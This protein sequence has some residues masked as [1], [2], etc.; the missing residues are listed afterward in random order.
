MRL[1]EQL[2]QNST[3][4][5]TIG[6]YAINL[7]RSPDRWLRLA[8]QAEELD[9]RLVRIT[10]VD[11]SQVP[12]AE[13][14]NCDERTFSRNNGRTILPGEYGCYRSHLKALSTFLE[15]NQPI[16][17]I[18]EDDIAFSGDLGSRVSAAFDALPDAEVIKLCNHRIVWFKQSARTAL[19]DEV[20]RA[21]WGPQGSAACYAVT[22]AGAAKLID[23]LARMDHPWDI[24][25]ERGWATGIETYTTKRDLVERARHP[26]T[27]ATRSAYKETKFPW[28]KRFGTLNHRIAESARRIS[29]AL[30][31]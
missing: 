4:T 31:G 6:I 10:G 21:A 18:A 25:L 20:G 22:R 19:G 5:M 15:V 3:G 17:I 26:T 9:L 16:G 12:V 29:Y 28:W 11:G 30:R 1:A 14:I 8:Q 7:E 13:W 27:I 2:R 23:R 24:A